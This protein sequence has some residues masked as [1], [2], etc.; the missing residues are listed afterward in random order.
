MIDQRCL[1]NNFW[2][3]TIVTKEVFSNENYKFM[4][5]YDIKMCFIQCKKIKKIMNVL[6]KTLDI[7]CA[8][9]AFASHLLENQST[10]TS[11]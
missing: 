4:K 5:M 9:T 2:D 8:W 7:P 6:L 11:R 1:R 3:A 10:R